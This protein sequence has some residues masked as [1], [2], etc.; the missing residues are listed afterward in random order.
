[1]VNYGRVEHSGEKYNEGD[2]SKIALNF[3]EQKML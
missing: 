2:D 1:M 3:N